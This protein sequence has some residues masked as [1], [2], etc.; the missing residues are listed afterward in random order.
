MI[1]TI[2]T[3][4][5][6]GWGLVVLILFFLAFVRWILQEVSRE[7]WGLV[8]LDTIFLLWCAFS[9]FIHPVVQNIT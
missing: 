8:A 9:I 4:M 1:D 5:N 6:S 2:Q 3:F 7:Q